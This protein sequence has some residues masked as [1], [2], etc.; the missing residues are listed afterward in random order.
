MPYNSEKKIIAGTSFDRRIKLSNEQ[1]EEIKR[2]YKEEHLSQ[3][4][5]ATIFKVSRKLISFVLFPEREK[6][7]R[8]YFRQAK[9][10]GLYKPTKEQRAETMREHRHYKQQ[11]S[12]EGKI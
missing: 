3:R 6:Q 11:L 12:I 1:R 9:R 10:N 4:T 7:S 8:E 5:L 2:L